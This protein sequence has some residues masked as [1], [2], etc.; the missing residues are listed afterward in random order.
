M[1]NYILISAIT[2]CLIGCGG[3]GG[4]SSANSPAEALFDISPPNTSLDIHF[5]EYSDL[6]SASQ[7]YSDRFFE[8][9]CEIHRSTFAEVIAEIDEATAPS[10]EYEFVSAG[11]VLTRSIRYRF[12]RTCVRRVTR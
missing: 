6:V 4:D 11:D 1:R 12:N 2:T 5:T 10:L 3:S 8:P 7:I 9:G